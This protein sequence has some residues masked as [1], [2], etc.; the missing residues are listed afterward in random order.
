LIRCCADK[1]RISP[2]LVFSCADL[3]CSRECV[4]ASIIF[5]YGL[6]GNIYF[7]HVG[8]FCLELLIR[9]HTFFSLRGLEEIYMLASII[10]DFLW[11]LSVCTVEGTISPCDFYFEIGPSLLHVI[12]CDSCLCVLWRGPSHHVIQ[13]SLRREKWKVF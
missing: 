12:F 2:E 11:L 8:K 5:N 4:L 7:W 13:A 3:L 10:T 6:E 9:R 1:W